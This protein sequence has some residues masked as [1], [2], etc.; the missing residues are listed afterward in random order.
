[1]GGKKYEIGKFMLKREVGKFFLNFLSSGIFWM[2]C[3]YVIFGSRFNFG[4]N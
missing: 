4:G 1:M 3:K 2:R